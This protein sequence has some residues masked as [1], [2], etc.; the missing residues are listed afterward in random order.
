MID[1]CTMEEDSYDGTVDANKLSKREDE[2]LVSILP[3]EQ[4]QEMLVS[5]NFAIKTT[6]SFQ[7]SLRITSHLSNPSI[8]ATNLRSQATTA[9]KSRTLQG[10]IVGSKK[11]ASAPR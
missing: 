10:C 3:P 11:C 6:S 4:R 5:H 1:S 7:H 2:L 9:K 8:F